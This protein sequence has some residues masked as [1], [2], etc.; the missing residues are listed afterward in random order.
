MLVEKTNPATFRYLFDL[1]VVGPVAAITEVVPLMRKQG[2]GAIV[3]VSSGTGFI[4]P[5]FNSVGDLL[6]FLFSPLLQESF[7]KKL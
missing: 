5:L 6:G 4:H 1:D 2:G 3:N 7:S